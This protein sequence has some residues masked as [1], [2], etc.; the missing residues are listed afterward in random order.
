[1]RLD[2]TYV[3]P[4]KPKQQ[5]PYLIYSPIPAVYIRGK[6]QVRDGEPDFS[7]KYFPKGETEDDVNWLSFPN[8]TDSDGNLK[9]EFKS[10]LLNCFVEWATGAKFNVF[11]VLT[12]KHKYL[13]RPGGAISEIVSGPSGGVWI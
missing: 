5:Y 1:M 4:E 11:L 13:A 3:E 8:P 6:I 7:F 2:G 9:E 12:E 10:Y